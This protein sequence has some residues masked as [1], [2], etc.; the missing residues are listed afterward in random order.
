MFGRQCCASHH[1]DQPSSSSIGCQVTVHIEKVKAGGGDDIAA[2]AGAVAVLKDL[3]AHA[4]AGLSA[5]VAA[6]P[7]AP[8]LRRLPAAVEA[9]VAWPALLVQAWTVRF[10]PSCRLAESG[11][12]RSNADLPWLR[13]RTCPPESRR[14]ARPRRSPLCAPPSRT[15]P[16]PPM[17]APACSARPRLALSKGR[18]GPTPNLRYWNARSACPLL[19]RSV[20]FAARRGLS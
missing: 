6:G 12:V 5:A 8:L 11:A 16:P 17:P 14:K 15:S 19:N 10:H 1:R 2:I 4:C 18:L 13:R 3:A 7:S 9:F 20:C